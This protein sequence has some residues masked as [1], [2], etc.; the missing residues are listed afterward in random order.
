MTIGVC[1]IGCGAR[2]VKHAAYWNQRD[3]ARVLA[4]Y[5]PD[6]SARQTLAE[7]IDARAFA[8]PLAAM[9]LDGVQ[10]VSV[11]TPTCFH[12]QYG[13]AAAERGRHVLVEKP[14]AMDLAEGEAMLAA[15][16]QNDVLLA[17]GFQYRGMSLYRRL[18]QAAD[19][20]ALGSP[21]M[22][23]FDG[24]AEVRAKRA[25]HR[26][27]MNNGPVL[28]MIGHWVDL[29]RWFTGDEPKRVSATGD[30]FGRDKEELAGIDD[31]AID[32][33]EVLVGFYAG[34][35]LSIRVV[36]GLPKGFGWK[37]EQSLV[38]PLGYARPEGGQFT[39]RTSAGAEVIDD[40]ERNPE[41]CVNHLAEAM[42]GRGAVMAD[43]HD[44][45]AAL[46]VSVAAFESIESG[47]AVELATAAV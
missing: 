3:D 16:E 7:Q 13:C 27:S 14:L 47:Q 11:C 8:D 31:L 30:V 5:D 19:R 32:A 2:G 29:M 22:A 40:S 33:A 42:Q 35:T 36:W 28:D 45:L 6:E 39:L 12:R 25:M 38:G 15:A 41:C 43:G 10:A 18:K 34:H 44:G 37:G 1:I 26:R 17:M 46:R 21:L 20:G 4:V 24:L 9:E 23:R